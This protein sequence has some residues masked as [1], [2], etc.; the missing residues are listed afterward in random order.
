MLFVHIAMEI[1]LAAVV[2]CGMYVGG[3]AMMHYFGKFIIDSK[4]IMVEDYCDTN[5]VVKSYVCR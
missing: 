5:R 3:I 1:A 4:A 2:L